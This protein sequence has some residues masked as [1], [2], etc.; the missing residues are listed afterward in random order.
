VRAQARTT[1]AGKLQAPSAGEIKRDFSPNPTGL[2]RNSIDGE[3]IVL[4]ST[5]RVGTDLPTLRV[6]RSGMAAERP[7]RHSDAERRNEEVSG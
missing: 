7:K 1:L 3:G 2:S 4:V 5:L 6:V